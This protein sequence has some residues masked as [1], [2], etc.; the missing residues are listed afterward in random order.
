MCKQYFLIVILAGFLFFPAA[1]F[2]EQDELLIG[3]IPEVNV[4]KQRERFSPLADYLSEKTGVKVKLTIFSKYGGTVERFR[5]LNL[6]GAFF[7]SFTGA[8]AIEQL[9]V[10]PL[11]RPVNLDGSSTYHGY[12]FV[13][14]D[15]GIR[16]VKDMKG[17]RMAFVDKAT[18][19]GYI[20]PIA[21]FKENGVQD[22][23]K[24]FR[25]YYFAGSHDAAIYAVLNKK[26]DVGAAK[27]SVY[28]KLK[29]NDPGLDRE[30]IIL[31]ESPKVPSNGLCVRKD[32]NRKLKGKFK[33]ALLDMDKDPKGKIVLEKFGALRFIETTASDY[34]PVF[35]LIKRA[36]IKK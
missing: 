9:G 2:A 35:D 7:G 8:T 36:G 1:A 29:R 33:S 17:K 19:A 30:L 20:F 18:T 25:E 16:N 23:D 3:L 22:I 13:R 12:I 15:S 14:K 21:Y 10:E 27:H 34:Q 4:F 11:A 28:D 6:D 32:L 24:Y 5:S 31:A 26:A